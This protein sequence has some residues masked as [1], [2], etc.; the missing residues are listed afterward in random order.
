[1]KKAKESGRL[2][3]LR[4]KEKMK[5]KDVAEILEITP[6]YLGMI[7]RGSRTPGFS[8]AKKFAD[9]YNVTVDEIFFKN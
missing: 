1:M 6:D 9:L 7:E 8:L 3:K 4:I 2:R 5:I